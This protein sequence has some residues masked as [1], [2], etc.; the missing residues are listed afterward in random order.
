MSLLS[1][2]LIRNFFISSTTDMPAA[3]EMEV[4]FSLKVMM[5][6]ER[7]KVYTPK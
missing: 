2:I 3:T 7:N 5:I 4:Q 6:K 1:L